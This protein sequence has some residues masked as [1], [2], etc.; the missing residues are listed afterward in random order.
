MT[1]EQISASQK[2]VK[3]ESSKA[4]VESVASAGRPAPRDDR[5]FTLPVISLVAMS[6]M[7]GMSEFII[8]GILPDIAEGL[9]VSLTTVGGLVSLFAFVYA[10]ATPIGA[11]IS[12]RFERFRTL[13]FLA[14]VF[15]IGNLMCAFAVGYGMLVAARIVIALISGTTV[16]VS[17]TFADDVATPKNRTKFVAWVFSGFSIASVFGVPIGTTIANMFG[18]RWSFHVINLLTVALIVLM[19]VV[20]PKNH[21]GPKSRFLAQF[22]IFTEKRI[23]G[24]I[25]AVVFAAAATYVFYTYLTPILEQEIGIP[26]QYISFALAAYGLA[27]LG[28]NLY[29][30]KLGDR[31]RGVVPLVK[32]RPIYLIQAVFMVAL[33]FAVL[34][35]L[36]G[37]AVLLVLG[38]LMYL[39]NTSSQILYMDVA[40]A[41]HPGS[42]NL[43]SSFNSMSFNIGIALGSAVGG[44]VTDHVGMRWLGPFGAIFAV[45]AYLTAVWLNVDLKRREAAKAK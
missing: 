32:G 24:G 11:S 41:T 12:S 40:A 14:I 30:G 29:G 5:F 20:L 33:P 37:C 25:L 36:I 19:C 3:S 9:N 16:A 43:A 15:L 34:N 42:L 4:A 38:F 35:P 18:W 28:S 44:L 10:P 8:V 45:L 2:N 13:L 1:Q 27:C 7:L 31:G 23:W 6:F 22:F 39:Q 17:M 26:E 21:Y